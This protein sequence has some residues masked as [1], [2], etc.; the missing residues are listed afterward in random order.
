MKIVKLVT[1][2]SVALAASV[3]SG[4]PLFAQVDFSGWWANKQHMDNN[5]SNQQ[6][7]FTGIPVNDEGRARALSYNLAAV[8]VPERQCP[9]YTPYYT[10]TGPFGLQIASTAE[11]LTQKLVAWEI[12]GWLDRDPMTI[13]MDGRPHPSKSAPHPPSG[14]TTGEWDGDTLIAHT[15]HFKFGDIK[16]HRAFSSDNATITYYVVRHD[17]LLTMMA[18]LEDPDYLAE[19]YVMS[20]PFKQDINANLFPSLACE[21]TEELPYLIDNPTIVPHYLP[22]KNPFVNDLTEKFHIPLEAVMGGPETMYPEFRKR[23]KEKFTLPPPCTGNYCG[24]PPA[25]PAGRGRGSTP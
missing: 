5:Y 10:H 20:V 21:P 15:T 18:M 9:V 1:V 8:S 3:L 12:G 25:P 6:V 17:D 19:P 13:W 2:G 24:G 11:P 7:D 14:F 4:I 22:G 23:I 16:R